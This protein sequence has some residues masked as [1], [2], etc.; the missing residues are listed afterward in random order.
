MRMEIFLPN[1]LVHPKLFSFLGNVV[2]LVQ[3]IYSKPEYVN[4][5]RINC[6]KKCGAKICKNAHR[7]INIYRGFIEKYYKELNEEYSFLGGKNIDH[8][9]VIE[10]YEQG[11]KYNAVLFL[12][13]L[14]RFII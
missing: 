9:N 14:I 7:R 8:L 4:E 5:C 1:Q 3:A 13:K 11:K 6:T 2:L 10:P 12:E